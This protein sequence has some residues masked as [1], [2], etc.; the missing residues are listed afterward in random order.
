[1]SSIIKANWSFYSKKTS[2]LERISF[3]ITANNFLL[4]CSIGSSL[5]CHWCVTFY[6][7]IQGHAHI[8]L[9]LF[10]RTEVASLQ[11]VKPAEALSFSILWSHISE[12]NYFLIFKFQIC[13]VK[14]QYFVYI[15]NNISESIQ[16]SHHLLTL[17][18]PAK[19]VY[20]FSNQK[21]SA[22][23]TQNFKSGQFI[24][25][26]LYQPNCTSSKAKQSTSHAACCCCFKSK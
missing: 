2:F 6:K 8:V 16:S 24:M 7:Y 23:V 10:L 18:K 9:Q 26:F 4:K 21:E 1:M 25:L 14:V 22:E 20:A 3:T 13:N 12:L 15:W 19:Y 11:L 5:Y 17:Q